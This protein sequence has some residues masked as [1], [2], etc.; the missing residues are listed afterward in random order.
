MK[1][2]SNE[3][4]K[5]YFKFMLRINISHVDL[6]YYKDD[7]EKYCLSMYCL[8]YNRQKCYLQVLGSYALKTQISYSKPLTHRNN[9]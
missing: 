6:D 8:S 9:K 2:R 1:I 5:G 3:P 4:L 7:Y